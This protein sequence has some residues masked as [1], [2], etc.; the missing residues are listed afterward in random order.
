[1]IFILKVPNISNIIVLLLKDMIFK[2][3]L[4]ITFRLAVIFHPYLIYSKGVLK[5]TSIFSPIFP[6]RSANTDYFP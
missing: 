1:M 6:T 5:I 3:A 2:D 4:S